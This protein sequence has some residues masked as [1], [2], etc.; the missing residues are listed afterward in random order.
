MQ[1]QIN[2]IPHPIMVD[3]QERVH[4][5]EKNQNQA[6]KESAERNT[7]IALLSKDVKDI[8]DDVGTLHK[9]I[10]KVLW[11]IV[12]AVITTAVGLFTTFVLTGGLNLIQ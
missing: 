4:H 10:S 6:L 2:P 1:G 8:K 9:G 5:L 3:L 11:T 7:A 12:C